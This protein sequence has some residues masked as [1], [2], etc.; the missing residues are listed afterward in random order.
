[1]RPQR[2]ADFYVGIVEV[3][4]RVVRE[5]EPF[6]HSPRPDIGRHRE[7]D[8]F[9]KPSSANGLGSEGV[10]DNLTTRLGDVPATPVRS[11]DSPADLDARGA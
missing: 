11:R 6:H 4:S 7:R 9:F 3:V 10:P 2:V 5:A 1:V 8:E